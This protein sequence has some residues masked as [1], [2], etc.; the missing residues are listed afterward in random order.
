MQNLV[1]TPID[2]TA[3]EERNLVHLAQALS[4]VRRRAASRRR[5]HLNKP[6]RLMSLSARL[7]LC[8]HS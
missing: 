2:L 8:D 4:S 6:L 7:P 3:V 5:E 1:G